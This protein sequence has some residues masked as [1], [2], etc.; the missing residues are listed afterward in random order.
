VV[1]Q[2]KLTQHSASRGKPTDLT[3]DETAFFI[4]VLK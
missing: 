1:P 2:K 4:F 3:L